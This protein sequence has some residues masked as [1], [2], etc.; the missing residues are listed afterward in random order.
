[1]AALVLCYQMVPKARA[2]PEP[3]QQLP[4]HHTRHPPLSSRAQPAALPASLHASQPYRH[5]GWH[6]ETEA[7]HL[8]G[9]AGGDWGTVLRA[10]PCCTRRD[11]RGA[12]G[13]ELLMSSQGTGPGQLPGGGTGASANGLCVPGCWGLAVR[14]VPGPLCGSHGKPTTSRLPASGKLSHS[15]PLLT[16]GQ[17]LAVVF[18][19]NNKNQDRGFPGGPAAKTALPVQRTWVQSP[20]RN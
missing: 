15:H 11:S 13:L 9:G 19:D 18:S 6:A 8:R 10:P 5:P 2:G 4:S 14:H 20:V 7:G 1:M 12:Q 16:M 17:A 3:R